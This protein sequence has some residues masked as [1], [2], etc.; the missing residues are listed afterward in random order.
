MDKQ[1]KG[2]LALAAVV[3]LLCAVFVWPTPYQ[4]NKSSYGETYRVNRF[5]G[6]EERAGPDGWEKGSAHHDALEQKLIGR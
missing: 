3:A 6:V 4:V 2:L 1:K 5:T